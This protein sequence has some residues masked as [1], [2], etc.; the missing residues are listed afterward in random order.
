MIILHVTGD[1]D[2]GAMTFESLNDPQQF[3]KQMIEEGVT[4]K[5]IEHEECG[6]IY[7]SIKE[8]GDVD[9]EF[10]EYIKDHQDYDESKN[11]NF[12]VVV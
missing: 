5:S 10:V 12:F 6:C 1:D 2:F 9:P 3:Y 7:I 11:T 8:F 4:E